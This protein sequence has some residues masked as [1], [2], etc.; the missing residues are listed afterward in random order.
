LGFIGVENSNN[1][2]C[3]SS[4]HQ[5]LTCNFSPALFFRKASYEA[6]LILNSIATVQMIWASE[7]KGY[8]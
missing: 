5:T 7:L 8:R 4:S 1:R 6:A 3:H 2:S